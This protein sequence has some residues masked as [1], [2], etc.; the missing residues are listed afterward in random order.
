MRRAE[1]KV[2]KEIRTDRKS[3]WAEANYYVLAVYN[4]LAATVHLRL[5]LTCQT[6]SK[7]RQ[8]HAR[9]I[10]V[11]LPIHLVKSSHNSQKLMFTERSS[12]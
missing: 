7:L 6:R 1:S 10:W 11:K 2:R 5:S 9:K 3:R 4:F 12:F 8:Y